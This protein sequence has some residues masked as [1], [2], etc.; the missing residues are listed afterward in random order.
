MAA[1]LATEFCGQRIVNPTVLASGIMGVSAA[2]LQRISDAGAGAVTCKSVTLQARKGHANPIMVEFDG[3]FLNAVGYSN[4]GVESALE[5]F[6]GYKGS[7]PLIFSIV[8]KDADEFALMAQKADALA[9]AAAIEIVLSCPH[10]PGYGTLAG[11]GTPEATREI[12]A[13][14]RENTRKPICVKLSPSMQA[15]GEVAKAAQEAGA[16]LINMGN[17]AGPGMVIDIEQAK[18]VLGF[19]V[20][21]ISGRALKPLAVRCVYDV[22]ESVNVPI[23]GTGGVTTGLDAV[24]MMMAG[25]SLVG[26]GTAVNYR[27]PQVFG[28]VADELSQWLDSHGYSSPKQIVGLAHEKGSGPESKDLGGETE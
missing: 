23:I 9:T 8:A 17:T 27:G 26:I 7:A 28:L 24:E 4:Q 1:D 25:A 15:I 20:G 2:S 3:G 21:G 12:T 16:D 13:A 6:S 22:Y 10:T 5:E 11:H 14:V 18:P 19:K